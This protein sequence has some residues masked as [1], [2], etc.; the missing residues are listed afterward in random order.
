VPT[1][2]DGRL[3]LRDEAKLVCLDLRPASR[4]AASSTER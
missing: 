3:Y 2:A 1:V 4:S